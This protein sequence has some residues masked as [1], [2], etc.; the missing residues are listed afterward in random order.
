MQIGK[1]CNINVLLGV[2]LG[3]SKTLKRCDD[4]L[5]LS[6]LRMKYS[7]TLYVDW[8]FRPLDVFVVSFW[9]GW[10]W[11][12]P[13]RDKLIFEWKWDCSR[14]NHSLHI[15]CM[16]TWCTCVSHQF[17]YWCFVWELALGPTKRKERLTS[18]L[19]GCF[20]SFS[21]DHPSRENPSFCQLYD[22]HF[23]I[24]NKETSQ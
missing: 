19:S 20:S 14:S 11:A 17:W 15:S 16:R 23:F 6:G 24:K 4:R 12:N 9:D 18:C 22:H 2:S 21:D 10:L 1:K 3:V 5:H 7:R 13:P 8:K